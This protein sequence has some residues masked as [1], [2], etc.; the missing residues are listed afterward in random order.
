VVRKREIAGFYA[1]AVY[2]FALN[3]DKMLI[4]AIERRVAYHSDSFQAYSSSGLLTYI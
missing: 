2:G 3:T 4:E 1:C